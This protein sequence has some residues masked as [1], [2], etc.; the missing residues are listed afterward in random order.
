MGLRKKLLS[1]VVALC[2]TVGIIPVMPTAS[3]SAEEVMFD[4]TDS[5]VQSNMSAGLAVKVSNATNSAGTN[6]FLRSD[7]S[8]TTGVNNWRIAANI[9][10]VAPAS[11]IWAAAKLGTNRNFNKFSFT[12]NSAVFSSGNTRATRYSLWSSSSDSDYDSL[13]EGGASYGAATPNPTAMPGATWQ[14]IL[15]VDNFSAGVTAGS[16]TTFSHDLPST[17]N[18]KYILLLIEPNPTPIK[19]GTLDFYA[20]KIMNVT[21][22]A[23]E[24]PATSEPVFNPIPT[25][26]ETYS[27]PMNVSI[28]SATPGATIFYTIDGITAPTSGSSLSVYNGGT[29][30]V[31]STTTIKAIASRDGMSNSAVKSQT[32]YFKAETPLL[33]PSPGANDTYTAP[34]SVTIASPTNGATVYYTTDGTA[35]TT[36]SNVYNSPITVSTTTTIKAIAV[37]NGMADSEVA[38]G[39]YVF[40]I[41]DN[42]VNWVDSGKLGTGFTMKTSAYTASSSGAA[43]LS[44]SSSVFWA[45]PN[46]TADQGI[47]NKIWAAVDLNSVKNIGQVSFSSTPV[48]ISGKRALG[49]SFYYTND[50]AAYDA[51]TQGGSN[52]SGIASATQNPLT[53]SPGKWQELVSRQSLA[54]TTDTTFTHNV[55]P[56]NA[57]YVLFLADPAVNL[58]CQ[59]YGFKVL[60]YPALDVPT[61][62]PP[63]GAVYNAGQT[64]TLSSTASGATIYYTTDGT[65]PKVSATKI[66]YINPFDVTETMTI[67][68][69]AV[70]ADNAV[71]DVATFAY[72]IDDPNRAKVPVFN[73]VPSETQKFY[74]PFNV[75]LTTETT[76]AT[77]YY[78]TDGSVP[79]TSSAV[80]S[81]PIKVSG[82]TTISAIAVKDGVFTSP[83]GKQTY[84][85]SSDRFF[86]GNWALQSRWNTA[87]KSSNTGAT[88]SL[89]TFMLDGDPVSTFWVTRGG[90]FLVSQGYK[91]WIVIDLKESRPFNSI[92]LK[93]RQINGNLSG[94]SLWYSNN[95]EAYNELVQV[96]GAGV[97]TAA[98]KDPTN[99]DIGRSAWTMIT[100][101]NAVPAEYTLYKHSFTDVNAR[102]MLVLLDMPEKVGT[103]PTSTEPVQFSQIEVVRTN[104][105]WSV[106]AIPTVNVT[107]GSYWEPQSLI[108]SSP[109]AGAKIYYTTDGSYPITSGAYASS[110]YSAPITIDRVMTIKAIVVADNYNDSPVAEFIY[111]VTERPKIVPPTDIQTVLLD[112]TMVGPESITADDLP[113]Q[114]EGNVTT[115]TN[116]AELI[117]AV[118]ALSAGDTIILADGIYDTGITI[119]DKKGTADNPILIKAQNRGAA[120][121]TNTKISMAI[122]RSDYITVDGIRFETVDATCVSLTACNSV[123]VTRCIFDPKRVTLSLSADMKTFMIQPAANQPSTDNRVDHCFFNGGYQRGMGQVIGMTGATING[124]IMMTMYDR[125]DHN[126]FKDIGPRI[127]NGMETIRVGVG[128]YS[129]ASAFA[130]IEYNLFENCDGDP[131]VVSLKSNDNHLRFNTF[132]NSRGQITFRQ[133]DRSEIYGN[134]FM[135]D[136]VKAGVGG[137]RSYGMSNKIASNYF[138]DLTLPAVQVDAASWDQ[139]YE[140]NYNTST[141]IDPDNVSDDVED[142]SLPSVQH[143]R[144]YFTE[145]INNVIINCPTGIDISSRLS[146][147]RK[148]GAVDTRVSG[149]IIVANSLEAIVLA[150]QPTV[151][152]PIFVPA[153]GTVYEG[154]IA[155]STVDNLTLEQ[156]ST[157]GTVTAGFT[158]ADPGFVLQPN[159]LY[160]W[161]LKK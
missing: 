73:P 131:E 64:I 128:A 82:S 93:T 62:N 98:T 91:Q 109:I 77:V 44:Q 32:Y 14:K 145:V 81:E 75:T 71:S 21:T 99:T 118:A 15:E 113:R 110:A 102:Y 94:Y 119:A 70:N 13:I 141:E 66:Q 117:A 101:T 2:M 42:R 105:D 133:S 108:L 3:V 19:A 53:Q 158:V 69:Y 9:T 20:L 151:D 45:S 152:D 160:T 153:R 56:V 136:G 58:Q 23:S 7:P 107:P 139:G 127:E 156:V 51:L 47:T 148:F 144:N 104:P 95:D 130:T 111:R 76:G 134:I 1:G 129:S 78:T 40:P 112:P 92:R 121:F 122:T 30:P 28:T 143:W 60:G 68:A 86:Y 39:T 65:D 72:T 50:K 157:S 154:N 126:Y 84:T 31:S 97:G 124:V 137:V 140:A 96:T 43:F 11:K 5:S 90:Q 12:A 83:V 17:F 54:D 135:G 34:I 18:G 87:I 49:Y 57:Q 114:G 4:W 100:Q 155:W 41:I 85:F 29:I 123:R 159:G 8:T 89:N 67:K 35:P 10:T 147:A 16:F 125:I 38:S 55:T 88:N 52:A 24:L 37:I 103:L 6:L 142:E 116:S 120:I 138:Q 25:P 26:G 79:T 150:D 59:F 106:A 33:N 161:G 36:A 61:A 74:E 80:Y 27:A 63:G 48:S 46:Y 132:K 115:V 146:T 149:N 22:A